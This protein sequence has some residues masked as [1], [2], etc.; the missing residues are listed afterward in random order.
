[1]FRGRQICRSVKKSFISCTPLAL[2]PSS[3]NSVANRFKAVQYKPECDIASSAL[4]LHIVSNRLL[5][6][7]QTSKSVPLILQK[8]EEGQKGENRIDNV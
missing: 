6:S 2:I 7:L 5:G 4:V 8:K 3:T 1:M